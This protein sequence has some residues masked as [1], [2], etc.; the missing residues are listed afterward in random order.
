MFSSLLIAVALCRVPLVAGLYL[1]ELLEGSDISLHEPQPVTRVSLSSI[2]N[3][4]LETN[5]WIVHSYIFR[6][7]LDPQHIF[8]TASYLK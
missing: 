8:V 6:H 1:H 4:F 3:V 2:A 7:G 5:V